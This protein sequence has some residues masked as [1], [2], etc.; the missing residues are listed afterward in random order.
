MLNLSSKITS[1]VALGTIYICVLP[2]LIEWDAHDID[3]E[4]LLRKP[5]TGPP[6]GFFYY[7][8]VSLI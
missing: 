3:L 5:Q 4:K 6:L 1:I 7:I 2:E 8:L